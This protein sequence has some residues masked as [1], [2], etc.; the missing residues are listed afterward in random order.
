MK[1]HVEGLPVLVTKN[2]V[3]VYGVEIPKNVSK[4]NPDR[5]IVAFRMRA[6]EDFV[7]AV[8]CDHEGNYTFVGVGGGADVDPVADGLVNS[9]VTVEDADSL[10]WERMLNAALVEWGNSRT[11]YRGGRTADSTRY[12]RACDRLDELLHEQNVGSGVVVPLLYGL[13]KCGADG[14]G[15]MFPVSRWTESAIALVSAQP[16]ASATNPFVTVD[17]VE[18]CPKCKGVRGQLMRIVRTA[19]PLNTY[20]ETL[21]H[22][23]AYTSRMMLPRRTLVD[24]EEAEADVPVEG[25]DNN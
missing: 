1:S 18:A 13:V 6:G 2:G 7:V 4:D 20:R 25:S 23:S 19:M 12:A 16:G 5:V 9:V 21:E 8:D 10:Y 17:E 11:E 22:V 3:T 15:W 14:C 24:G